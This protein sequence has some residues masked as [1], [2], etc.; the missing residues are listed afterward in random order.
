[1]V[2]GHIGTFTTEERMILHLYEHPLPEGEWEA[3]QS[4]TQSGIASAVHVQRKHVPRTLSRLEKTEDLVLATR[5]VPGAKQRRKVYGLTP[6]GRERAS[7][8]RESILKEMVFLGEERVELSTLRNAGQPVLELLAHL[9]EGL[10]YHQNPVISPV[11]NPDGSAS[12]DAQSGELLVKRLM[13]RAWEDCK[14]TTD[15][16]NLL[17]EVVGFLSMHPERVHRLSEE[18]RRERGAP[19]PEEVYKDMLDQAM[20][21]GVLIEDEVALLDT[22]RMAFSIDNATHDKLLQEL[23][24]GLELRSELQTYSAAMDTALDDGRITADEE[25]ILATLRVS[26]DI[27]EQEHANLLAE[28][29]DKMT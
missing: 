24:E 26:L 4:L 14:I 25:A 27:S 7:K 12:L 28:K 29:R 20:V 2:D 6:K 16:Q 9:D 23:Q 11:S 1:M 15:E 10:V 19:P 17:D 18:A 8:L 13:A 22:M 5:H 3:P 21:D